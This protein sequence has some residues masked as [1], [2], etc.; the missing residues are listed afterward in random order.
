PFAFD[1]QLQARVGVLGRGEPGTRIRWYEIEPCYVFHVANAFDDGDDMIADVVVY[2]RTFDLGFGGLL[3]SDLPRLERWRFPADG[4]RVIRTPIDDRALEFP[5]ID[6]QVAGSSYNHMYGALFARRDGLDRFPGYVKYNANTGESSRIELPDHLQGNEPLFVRAE[7]GKADDEGW[8]VCVEYD[9]S[10]DASDLVIYD[11]HSMTNKPEA[12]VH[13]P[14]RIPF[15][16]H[17]TFVTRE[18]LS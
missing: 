16:F 13:L 9:R 6:R 8:L 7:D 2:N 12:R 3:G 15:G 18:Q 14:V 5:V 17:G 11:A 1:D 10:R 4:K